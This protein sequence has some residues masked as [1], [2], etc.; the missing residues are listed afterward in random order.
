MLDPLHEAKEAAAAWNAQRLGDQEDGEA[1]GD[2]MSVS[3]A[4]VIVQLGAP[5][6]LA[7]RREVRK[8]CIALLERWLIGVRNAAQA[9]CVALVAGPPLTFP[10]WPAAVDLEARLTTQPASLAA[11]VVMSPQM[12]ASPRRTRLGRAS[13]RRGEPSANV[14]EGA[15][16]LYVFYASDCFE[17][18]GQQG[19]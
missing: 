2:V 15:I 12:H 5:K 7:T 3:G 9:W 14:G 18:S 13:A 19:K 10:K 17:S 4:S 11:V 1:N 8:E 6:G 16:E